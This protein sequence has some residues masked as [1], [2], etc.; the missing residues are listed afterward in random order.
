M[1]T[2]TSRQDRITKALG[3]GII[4]GCLAAIVL[5]LASVWL[6]DRLGMFRHTISNLAASERRTVIDDI[7]DAGL[8]AF[9]AAV[10]ATAYGLGHW[11]AERRD[12]QVGRL[13]LVVVAACVALIAG[14]EAYTQDYG[15]MI[16]YKLVYALGIAFPLAVLLTAGHFGTLDR[17]LGRAFFAGG[18]LWAAAAPFLFVVATGSDGIYERVLAT[19]MLAWFIAVGVLIRRGP[20]A[21]G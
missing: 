4:A 15:P 2:G 10:L 6:S 14:Y 18:V 5:D 13:A 3:T 17:R 11:R 21:L 16:H 7:S 19:L 1:E 12:W 8:Y 9:A 20:R